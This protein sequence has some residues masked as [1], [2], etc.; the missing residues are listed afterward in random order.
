MKQFIYTDWS[1]AHDQ[2]WNLGKIVAS[3]FQPDAIIAIARGGLVVGRI[4]ADYFSLMK[5]YTV[6]IESAGTQAHRVTQP[7]VYAPASLNL[8]GYA[9]LVVDYY[10][11]T[12]HNKN[13][14]KWS[15]KSRH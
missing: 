9:I 7:Q 4:L 1:E 2:A 6:N 5:L 15:T 11:C 12:L 8:Q 14:I 3:A 13:Y 10:L